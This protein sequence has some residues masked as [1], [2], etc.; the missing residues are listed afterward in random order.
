MAATS[1]SNWRRLP[2]LGTC[3][4]KSCSGS[5]NCDEDPLRRRP[6]ESTARKKGEEKATGGV[7]LDGEKNDRMAFQAR[8]DY[9]SHAIGWLQ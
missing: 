3:F 9:Q 4:G 8:A 7:C 1:R 5:M 2:C 6:R